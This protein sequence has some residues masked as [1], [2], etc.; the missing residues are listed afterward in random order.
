MQF[1]FFY[2]IIFLSMFF[3]SCSSKKVRNEPVARKSS[4]VIYT[5]SSSSKNF[6]Y[7]KFKNIRKN[8]K[9]YLIDI[10]DDNVD[11][12]ITLQ[13]SFSEPKFYAKILAVMTIF[14]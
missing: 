14:F 2:L 4:L 6:V 5:A 13:D 1:K 7:K 9:N 11:E 10:D 8:Q 12:L 3:L